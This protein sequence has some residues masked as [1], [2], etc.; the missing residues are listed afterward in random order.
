MLWRGPLPEKLGSRARAALAAAMAKKVALELTI[1]R[2]AAF[3][4]DR[5][6]NFTA[7]AK[8]YPGLVQRE[9]GACW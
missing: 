2:E 5:P 3:M 9:T 7:Y 1:E 4:E 6:P 8:D